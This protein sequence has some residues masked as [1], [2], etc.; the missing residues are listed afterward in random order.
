MPLTGSSSLKE[1][2]VDRSFVLRSHPEDGRPIAMEP[3]TLYKDGAEMGKGVTD[4]QGR[5]LIANHQPGTAAYKVKLTNGNEFELPVTP[6]LEGIDQQ[7]SAKGYRAAQ[8]AAADRQKHHLQ[9][10]GG[11]DET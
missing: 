4:A 5:V 9:R 1:T 3:Y 8:G 6:Q 10:Q 7:L 11:P 2:K